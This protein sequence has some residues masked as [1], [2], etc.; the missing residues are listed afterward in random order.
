VPDSVPLAKGLSDALPAGDS[1]L[2]RVKITDGTDVADVIDLGTFAGLGQVLLDASGDPIDPA[3]AASFDHGSNR[4]VDATAEQI[5]TTSVVPKFGILVR[6][7]PGNSGVVYVGNSDVTAGTT[8]ATDGMPLQAGES[9]LIKIDNVNK[10]YVIG[11][12]VNQIVY[13]LAV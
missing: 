10:I 7:A 1:V 2:G 8:D 6:A 5:T 12:A 9:V 3:P 13:W 11:S 4:D